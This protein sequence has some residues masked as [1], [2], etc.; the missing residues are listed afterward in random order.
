MGHVD[1]CVGRIDGAAAASVAMSLTPLDEHVIDH[2]GILR[3]D[4]LEVD[5]RVTIRISGCQ[6]TNPITREQFHAAVT[7]VCDCYQLKAT[8]W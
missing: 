5:D 8:Y 2:G 1:A 6:P 7:R 4:M 3:A